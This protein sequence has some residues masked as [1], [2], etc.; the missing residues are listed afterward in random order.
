MRGFT[1]LEVMVVVLIIG[2]V[3]AL[4][5]VNLSNW[6]TRAR[7]DASGNSL[8]AAIAGAR[9]QAILDGYDAFL[10]LGKFKADGEVVFGYRLKFTNIKA[11]MDT[12]NEEENARLREEEAAKE[13]VWLYTIWRELPDDCE[14]TGVSTTKGQWQR[15]N[16][17][18]PFA[19]RFDP[20]GNVD[21]AVAIRVELKNADLKK[22]ARTLTV[23][24][25]G[26]TSQANW[27]MGEQ[28]LVQ[29]RPVSDFGG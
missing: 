21:Q 27:Q 11:A 26:L 17:D 10:E 28:D 6:G 29:R 23:T 19:V 14:I 20:A 4:V 2:G 3:L 22:E 15:I 24:V 7:L 16:Q 13:R 9:E 12:G 5:P 8:V 25:N 18:R 1:L